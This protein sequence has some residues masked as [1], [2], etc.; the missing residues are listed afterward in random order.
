MSSILRSAFLCGLLLFAS[1]RMALASTIFVGPYVPSSTMPFVV[2]VEITGAS[3]LASFSF[4]LSYD[5]AA[6]QIN[7][8]CD[9]FMDAFCDLVTGPITL[10][11]FYTSAST[12]P[13]LF[14]PGFVL[15]D[16]AGLQIGSLVGVNGA[17]QDFAPAPSGDGILA[18]VEFVATPG[19]MPRGPIAVVGEPPPPSGVPEPPFAALLCAGLA[20]ASVMRRRRFTRRVPPASADATQKGR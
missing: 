15:L 11:T 5:A 3:D 6:Y 16:G 10:G 18:F 17:W 20:A 14:N 4:D 7:T 12:V 19:A 8:A 9:P 1:T 13:S 2:P